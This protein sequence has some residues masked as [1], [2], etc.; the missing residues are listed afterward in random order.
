MWALTNISTNSRLGLESCGPPTDGLSRW[1]GCK[2]P[3]CQAGEAG[4]IPGL[5]RCPLEERMATHSSIFAWIIPWTE[6]PGRLQSMGSLRVGQDL[7]TEQQQQIPANDFE[8]S[9]SRVKQ[10]AQLS[11]GNTWRWL[12]PW[13]FVCRIPGLHLFG[14]S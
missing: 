13:R 3:A 12:G 14:G 6:E 9:I 2:E 4:S 11:G 10:P 8:F 7:A 5:R 1:L